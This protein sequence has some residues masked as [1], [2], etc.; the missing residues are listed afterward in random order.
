MSL[1]DV[2]RMAPA[3]ALGRPASF[4]A[5]RVSFDR[6]LWMGWGSKAAATTVCLD[7]VQA[8]G[9]RRHQGSGRHSGV[10]AGFTLRQD[11]EPPVGDV[12]LSP[13]GE[14]GLRW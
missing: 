10:A 14:A 3:A 12:R 9:Y 13:R 5:R 6:R 1:P 2:A 8:G 7:D 4:M 11:S